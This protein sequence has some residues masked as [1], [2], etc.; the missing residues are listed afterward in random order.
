MTEHL[1]PERVF[2]AIAGHRNAEVEEHLRVCLSCDAEVDRLQTSIA[3]LS[4]AIHG[5]ST[6]QIRWAEL[7]P[8]SRTRQFT[9][10]AAAAMIAITVAVPVY[11]ETQN[12]QIE[13][14]GEADAGLL[15]EVD[16]QLSRE[17]P[18]SMQ[19]LMELML[20]DKE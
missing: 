12:R 2:E 7:R 19:S 15:E 17:V 11:E 3:G 8:Q 10:I 16:A 9:W 1:S 20:E 18:A 5:V 13:A 14:M 6:P 4:Q